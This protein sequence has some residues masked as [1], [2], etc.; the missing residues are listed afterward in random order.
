MATFSSTMS[1]GGILLESGAVVS[2]HLDFAAVVDVVFILVVDVLVVVVVAVVDADVAEDCKSI[3]II[4]S[5]GLLAEEEDDGD[6]VEMMDLLSSPI[7]L[8]SLS[9]KFSNSLK[10]DKSDLNLNNNKRRLKV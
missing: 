5:F 2:L 6:W 1:M 10:S 7:L 8:L 9:T 3:L 4:P